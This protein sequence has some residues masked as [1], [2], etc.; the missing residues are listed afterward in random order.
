MSGTGTRWEGALSQDTFRGRIGEGVLNA[1]TGLTG[2][3][4]G[5]SVMLIE[6]VA[7]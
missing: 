6:A 7:F 4:T 2:K 1:K 3:Q 5:R